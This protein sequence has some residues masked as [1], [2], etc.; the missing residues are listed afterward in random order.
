MTAKSRR[1]LK[2]VL[3]DAMIVIEAHRVGIWHDLISKVQ[4]VLPATVV[5]DEAF[6]FETKAG[7]KA[8]A[9]DLGGS[10]ESGR[11]TQE[12]ATLEELQ[13]LY[14]IFDDLTLQGLHPGELEALALLQAEK[15]GDAL[16]CTS[17]AAAIRALA[18][19]GHHE[20]GISLESM[21]QRLGLQQLLESQYTEEY[22]RSNVRKGQQDR[23]T[24]TGLRK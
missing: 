11:I 16:L 23:I 17:D 24:R 21:L 12:A 20:S 18:L 19:M 15:L 10:I 6:Y 7:R 9:I 8:H 14:A 3:L 5:R 4:V 2:C 13:E 1:K 22:F